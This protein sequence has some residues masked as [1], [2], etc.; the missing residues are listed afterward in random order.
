[1]C[2]AVPGKLVE[3]RAADPLPATGAVGTVDFQGSR[4]DV[5]LA[6]VPEAKPG[7]WLLVH[8]GFALNVLD[9]QEA[10]ETWKYL[11]EIEDGGEL[12]GPESSAKTDGR[13]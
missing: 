10:A 13:P 3:I 4:L 5:S 1:M 2:L 8:A 11:Q 12:P 6:F 7:D 9:E